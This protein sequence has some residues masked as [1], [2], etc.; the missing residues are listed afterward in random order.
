MVSI[1]RVCYQLHFSACDTLLA[2]SSFY[3]PWLILSNFY[4]LFLISVMKLIA[5]FELFISLNEM[6]CNHLSALCQKGHKDT[7]CSGGCLTCTQVLTPMWTCVHPCSGSEQSRAN[8]NLPGWPF[9]ARPRALGVRSTLSRGQRAVGWRL[10]QGEQW[11][12]GPTGS[13][14]RLRVPRRP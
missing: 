9:S 11:G 12:L 8:P 7:R 5:C 14:S 3:I 1:I 10:S 13:Q 2:V 4:Q 6:A